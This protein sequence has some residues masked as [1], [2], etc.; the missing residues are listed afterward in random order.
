MKSQ[1]TFLVV[2]IC[3]AGAFSCTETYTN[4]LDPDNETVQVEPPF[5]LAAQVL[6]DT[7]IAL[8]WKAGLNYGFKV[9][10]NGLEIHSV[11]PDAQSPTPDVK[12][13]RYSDRSFPMGDT[14]VYSILASL[15]NGSVSSVQIG[16][17]VVL[18]APGNLVITAL[19]KSEVKVQWQDNSPFETGY[20]VFRKEAGG[21]YAR[22][23]QLA[24]NT[25]QF[26]DAFM[27]DIPG[28]YVYKVEV[29]STRARSES[30]EK[31]VRFDIA[32][33]ENFAVAVAQNK[34]V[35]LT[36]RL[37]STYEDG[38]SVFRKPFG[39]TTFEKI[40]DLSE[41]V[42][43]YSDTP[44]FSAREQYDYRLIAR[45][46]S[47]D[48]N[49]QERTASFPFAPDSLSFTF[50]QY[51]KAA[52]RF[53]KR[54]RLAA[55]H[56]IYR[57]NGLQSG[58]TETLAATISAEQSGTGDWFTFEDAQTFPIYFAANDS[59]NRVVYRVVNRF[60]GNITTSSADTNFLYIQA[61]V[62]LMSNASSFENSFELTWRKSTPFQG[63]Y[64][65]YRSVDGDGFTL[66]ETIAD[67]S[68][69][70]I[71]N[72]QHTNYRYRVRAK[73]GEG[74]Y[75][76]FSNTIKL[77][78]FPDDLKKTRAI[79]HGETTVSFSF[80]QDGST[81]ATWDKTIKLWGT[82]TGTAER[83]IPQRT[84]LNV[85]VTRALVTQNE[86]IAVH[87]YLGL[88]A[89]NRSNGQLK[90][91][92]PLTDN[93]QQY[94]WIEFSRDGSQ[95]GL[96]REDSTIYF[97]NISTGN[98]ES[99]YKHSTS[100]NTFYWE[101]DGA[102]RLVVGNQI[103]H[104]STYA[105]EFAFPV[106]VNAGASGQF[107]GFTATKILTAQGRRMYWLDRTTGTATDDRYLFDG[108][109]FS[110]D[111]SEDKTKL[112]AVGNDGTNVLL[113]V[114]RLN[115]TTGHYSSLIRSESY[116]TWSET[117]RFIRFSP[118]K[119]ILMGTSGSSVLVY[120]MTYNWLQTE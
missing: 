8:E 102:K 105:L 112:Y 89:Y 59:P 22:I 13:Y 79:G 42:T 54:S 77:E 10:R 113:K 99:T 114:F 6:A 25:T 27:F 24:Q 110:Y 52:L 63:A 58:A 108:G 11:S 47:A 106:T 16:R 66:L 82:A 12:T 80:S 50:T 39:A 91:S 28:E 36:W 21:G 83:T 87:Y 51:N 92:Y 35:S 86:I 118:D 2:L 40:A 48:S 95:V 111:L 74:T 57:I 116:N 1:T 78:K 76:P 97:Y 98:L 55:E 119:T 4:P 30:T 33:P 65:I 19:S 46:R 64:E 26:I 85:G 7:L 73:F 84:G 62:N 103:L 14:L 67:T 69:L 49:P 43:T 18:G 34:T 68:R 38:F 3:S 20:E 90:W 88:F 61:P 60:G 75:S 70:L 45:F 41:D 5:D 100:I 115:T 81:V 109:I 117:G 29:L 72:A 15:P 96:V 53:K 93:K 104:P 94:R 107:Y 37:N 120:E 71:G 44:D 31:S 9:Q 23:A 101:P 56:L 32:H 17:K